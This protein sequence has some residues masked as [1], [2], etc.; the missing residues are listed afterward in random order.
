MMRAI[1][2]AVSIVL[3]VAIIFGAAVAVAYVGGLLWERFESESVCCL[4]GVSVFA[5]FFVSF[6][7]VATVFGRLLNQIPD[8]TDRE[9]Q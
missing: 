4:Y 7:G 9:R 3:A 8:P 6:F 2:L 5:A 1:G